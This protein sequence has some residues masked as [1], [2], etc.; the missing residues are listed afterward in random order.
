M[1]WPTARP[2]HYSCRR[3][4]LGSVSTN[5][6]LARATARNLV[7]G[8]ETA[9]CMRDCCL[10]SAN[11]ES[12]R[13][14]TNHPQDDTWH[15]CRQR[16]MRSDTCRNPYLSSR[17]S[18][19]DGHTR[20]TDQSVPPRQGWRAVVGPAGKWSADLFASSR[21]ASMPHQVHVN[22]TPAGQQQG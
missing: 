20:A 4:A 1:K 17:G 6:K 19:T 12:T 8:R 9:R 7:S 13:Q 18:C 16:R 14:A 2:H 22:P 3:Q 15:A 10:R 11:Q 5:Q 21:P